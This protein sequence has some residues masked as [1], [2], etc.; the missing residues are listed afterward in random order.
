MKPE[1]SPDTDLRPEGGFYRRW[2]EKKQAAQQPLTEQ[3]QAQEEEQLAGRHT[4][5]RDDAENE[6]DD[7]QAPPLIA[8]QADAT[9]EAER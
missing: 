4:L 3:N 7:E 9:D 5:D 6:V 1:D 8:Q 2:S